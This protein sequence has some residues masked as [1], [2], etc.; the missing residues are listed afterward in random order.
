MVASASCV[1]STQAEALRRAADKN[2]WRS[3]REKE[4]STRAEGEGGEAS[5]WKACA[6]KRRRKRRFR[7][8]AEQ[9]G[10]QARALLLLH[11]DLEVLVDD[12]D[13]HQDPRTRPDGTDDVREDRQQADAHSTARCRD[14]EIGRAHV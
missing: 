14:R 3:P 10:Q 1:P 12:R 6:W 5:G 11:D 4:G 2:G 7:L 8:A 13:R 9:R